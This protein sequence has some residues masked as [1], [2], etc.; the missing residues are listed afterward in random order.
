LTDLLHSVTRQSRGDPIV[1]VDLVRGVSETVATIFGILFIGAGPAKLEGLR[2]WA[3]LV[4]R[5]PLSLF[6]RQAI[7]LGVPLAEIGIGVLAFTRP[8]LG[9]VASS[10]LLLAFTAAL[11][12][13]LQLVQGAEC[14]CFG[15]VRV[16]KIDAGL[17]GRNVVLGMLAAV[18]AGG[19][20]LSDARAIP[21]LQIAVVG[22]LA[23]AAFL[24]VE[25]RSLPKVEGIGELHAPREGTETHG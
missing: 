24:L 6:L 9:L 23:L 10:L 13:Y 5:F 11:M 14:N 3:S 2:G 4:R 15:S 7:W 8:A 18:A 17:I 1:S 12:R 16:S 19:S 25:Y 22:I 21:L 20:W